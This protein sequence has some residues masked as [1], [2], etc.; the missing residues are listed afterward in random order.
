MV[1]IVLEKVRPSLR[2]ELSRWMI[3]PSTGVFLGHVSGLVRDL[4]WERCTASLGNGGC[5]MVYPAQT[6]QG[7]EI[8][9]AGNLS[10]EILRHEGLFLVRKPTSKP[11]RQDGTAERTAEAANT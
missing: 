5:M 3:E 7:F 11:N 4:L 10:R 8:C 6:E 1:V 2:G 9:V